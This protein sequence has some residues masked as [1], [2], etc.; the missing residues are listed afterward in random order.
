[1]A[2]QVEETGTVSE[3]PLGRHLE[4]AE[5]AAYVDRAS[6]DSRAYVESHLAECAECRAELVDAARLVA[7]LPRRRTM[8]PHIWIPAAAAAAVLLMFVWPRTIRE[9]SVQHREAA[10]TATVSPRAVSPVGIVDSATTLRWS[11]V[12]RSDRYQIRLFDSDGSVLW[13]RETSDS[14]AAIPTSV[15]LQS[16]R[17]YYWKVEAHTGFNRSAASELAEF[18]IRSPPRP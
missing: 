11:S 2:L 1:M 6:G 16:G 10:V 8:R 17:S 3:Q 13:E 12:P 7:T 15:R 4:P 9:P 5:I 18:S 14:S